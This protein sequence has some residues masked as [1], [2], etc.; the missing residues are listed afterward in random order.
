MIA[1]DSSIE[2]GMQIPEVKHQ[3]GIWLWLPQISRRTKAKDRCLWTDLGRCCAGAV[4]WQP[5]TEISRSRPPKANHKSIESTRKEDL[6]GFGM[7]YIYI[8]IH[9]Y[10]YIQHIYIYIGTFTAIPADLIGARKTAVFWCNIC[11]LA[12]VEGQTHT[13]AHR[14]K[15]HKV[16]EF[17]CVTSKR[18]GQSPK[19][20]RRPLTTTFLPRNIR[21]RIYKRRI[22]KPLDPRPCL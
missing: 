20:S 21:C 19:Q 3:W 4:P 12:H 1:D 9:I 8:L 14:H 22:E 6:R 11:T 13:D 17:W 5:W 2:C 7:I 18:S 15:T 10:I 16:T